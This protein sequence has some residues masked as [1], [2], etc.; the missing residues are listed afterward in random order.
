MQNRRILFWARRPFPPVR[1]S[2]TQPGAPRV[3]RLGLDEQ[4]SK[5]LAA[6]CGGRRF[7]VFPT[8]VFGSSARPLRP[9]S[10]LASSVSSVSPMRLV[11]KCPAHLSDTAQLLYTRVL[12]VELFFPDAD[13]RLSAQQ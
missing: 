8:T 1:Q 13:W 9:G 3:A 10:V 5:S 7:E 4:D 12:E 11:K 6:E 2:P